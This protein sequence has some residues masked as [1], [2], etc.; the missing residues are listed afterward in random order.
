MFVYHM[1]MLYM[2]IRLRHV[3]LHRQLIIITF[4]TISLEMSWWSHSLS[5]SKD[6]VSREYNFNLKEIALF[7]DKIEFLKIAIQC[8]FYFLIYQIQT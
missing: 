7:S 8:L 3:T 1:H 5:I 6:G 2:D 4:T